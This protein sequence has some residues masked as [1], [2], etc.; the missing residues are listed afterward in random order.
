MS[1]LHCFVQV[2]DPDYSLI[3]TSKFLAIV[4]GPK[5]PVKFTLLNHPLVLFISKYNMTHVACGLDPSHQFA[6]KFQSTTW[7]TNLK[8]LFLYFGK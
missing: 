5:T 2:S 8:L 1:F 4:M 3:K 6:Y 7:D